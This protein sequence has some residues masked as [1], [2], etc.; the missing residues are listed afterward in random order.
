[1]PREDTW[2][3]IDDGIGDRL[4]GRPQARRG[5]CGA[6]TTAHR[7]AVRKNTRGVQKKRA[8]LRGGGAGG[9]S[10][11]PRW[12]VE[13]S[14]GEGLEE[15]KA[16]QLGSARVKGN[17]CC[18]DEE[19]AEHA[20]IISGSKTSAREGPVESDLKEL[21]GLCFGNGNGSEE[22]TE[23]PSIN[24]GS[25][26][27]ACENPVETDLKELQ[28]A[29][30]VSDRNIG[31]FFTHLNDYF[32]DDDGLIEFVPASLSHLL[33]HGGGAGSLQFDLRSPLFTVFTVNNNAIN[34][35]GQ[36]EGTHW[37]LLVFDNSGD[38]PICIHHDSLG[39]ANS[40]A[41]QDLA[42]AI[43]KLVPNTQ[44]D[45]VEASTPRQRNG[46]DCAIFVM[47]MAR[48]IAR[49]WHSD[50][51]GD[52]IARIHHEVSSPSVAALRRQ[53]AEILQGNMSFA[54]LEHDQ[55]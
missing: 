15:N 13:W 44:Q 50:D 30:F 31:R 2:E 21:G 39:G 40:S 55:V 35:Y 36:G 17:G 10:E 51:Q 29:C 8:G 49:R 18:N 38:F 54:D 47:A 32:G 27:T 52:W 14:Q 34:I 24:S 33:A 9:G 53:L 43:R 20:P 45:I 5:R 42:D 4:V 19:K 26:T 41:A 7:N 37:S 48:S 6:P 3:R 16:L 23:H 22:N 11:A 12:F 28:G 46:W 25:K 1:M